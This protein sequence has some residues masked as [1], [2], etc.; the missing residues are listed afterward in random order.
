MN[1]AAKE[2]QRKAAQAKVIA[3]FPEI[4]R[5]EVTNFLRGRR[6]PTYN[7]GLIYKDLV[8]KSLWRIEFNLNSWDKASTFKDDWKKGMEKEMA[9]AFQT[10]LEDAQRRGEFPMSWNGA[11]TIAC[12]VLLRD[13]PFQFYDQI[14]MRGLRHWITNWVT[15]YPMKIW[16]MWADRP[17]DLENLESFLSDDVGEVLEGVF[18][19]VHERGARVA[20]ESS[21][22]GK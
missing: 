4:C 9:E 15:G 10:A 12:Q 7:S 14:S 18:E 11:C 19:R 8:E 13:H 5:E 1:R 3:K 6:Y 20:R 22:K 21:K 2:A 16:L 17:T